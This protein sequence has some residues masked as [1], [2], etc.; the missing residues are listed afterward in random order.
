MHYREWIPETVKA[1]RSAN[2][3]VGRELSDLTGLSISYLSDIENGRTL[4]TIE[5]LDKILTAL[6]TTLTLGVQKD[7]VP[8]DYVW[9]SRE[10]LKKL[11]VDLPHRIGL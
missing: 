7:Y 11:S 4:P 2:G 10:T 6:G 8:P 9:V 5:T 1:L 3:L